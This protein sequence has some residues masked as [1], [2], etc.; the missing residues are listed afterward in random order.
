MRTFRRELLLALVASAWLAVPAGLHSAFSQAQ[1]FVPATTVRDNIATTIE[2]IR[3]LRGVPD[4][5]VA[6]R[7]N[8]SGPRPVVAGG[9][10]V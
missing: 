8:R 3:L 10:L 2:D 9:A 5:T 1:S 6:C 4:G 7:G